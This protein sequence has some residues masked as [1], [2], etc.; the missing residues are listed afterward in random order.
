[1][2]LTI[3]KW[4]QILSNVLK[5]LLLSH[6][7]KT[8]I[9]DNNNFGTAVSIISKELIQNLDFEITKLSNT[10]VIIANSTC[11][12]ALRR[13]PNIKLIIRSLIELTN[14][15]VLE[16]S[17]KKII[18]KKTF[19]NR[20]YFFNQ[21]KTKEIEEIKS[22][23][24]DET[25]LNKEELYTNLLENKYS[26]TLYLTRIEE[27]LTIKKSKETKLTSE[28]IINE[29]VQVETLNQEQVKEATLILKEFDNLFLTRSDILKYATAVYY[30]ID[31]ENV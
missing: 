20:D 3:P 28:E 21:Y 19:S 14:F 24:I 26:L 4:K 13:I 12:Y 29:L 25:I 10:I 11:Q 22:F 8:N 6:T 18:P 5:Q 23:H 9:A 2:L 31:T 17:E 16:N 1:Q 7:K 27:V 15:Q 30:K